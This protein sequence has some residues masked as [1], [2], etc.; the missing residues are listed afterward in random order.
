MAEFTEIKHTPHLQSGELSLAK[1]SGNEYPT[2]R[3]VALREKGL[4]HQMVYSA[5]DVFLEKP[6]V[7]KGSHLGSQKAGFCGF[8]FF[9]F[10]VFFNLLLL[11]LPVC[12]SLA[13]RE[14][15]FQYWSF[16]ELALPS[17]PVTG[18]ERSRLPLMRGPPGPTALVFDTWGED[19]QARASQIRKAP[20]NR[21]HS[22]AQRVRRVEHR[23]KTFTEVL[24]C[25]GEKDL[26][27]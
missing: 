4:H 18:G 11:T 9:A 8:F 7:L 6:L 10:L 19:V 14:L 15:S 1:N 21:H 27:F 13:P 5:Q 22:Q 20:R 2:C 23:T 3:G 17:L 24:Q 25:K 26:Q 16:E 12:V